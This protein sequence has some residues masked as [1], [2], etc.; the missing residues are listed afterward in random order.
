MKPASDDAAAPAHDRTTQALISVLD[1]LSV[2]KEEDGLLRS[3][4]EHV[5]LAL[6]ATGGLTVLGTDEGALV[7]AAHQRLDAAPSA[8]HSPSAFGR[9]R[10]DESRE[11]QGA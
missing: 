7:T 9:R 6:E 3:T 5:V 10:S 2:Q 11:Q 8:L 1:D 4:L